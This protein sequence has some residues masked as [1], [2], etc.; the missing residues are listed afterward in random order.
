MGV[1]GVV[2]PNIDRCISGENTRKIIAVT[3]PTVFTI[4]S[5]LYY[6][7]GSNKA[8]SCNEYLFAFAHGPSTNL[9][10]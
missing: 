7:L 9:Q 2:G 4:L 1:W 10:V 5:S 3:F 6:T 8:L